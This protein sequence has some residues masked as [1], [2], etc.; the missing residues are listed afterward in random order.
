MLS[1][2]SISSC[3]SI[4]KASELA[5]DSAFFSRPTHSPPPSPPLLKAEDTLYTKTLSLTEGEKRERVVN[6]MVNAFPAW[7]A[8]CARYSRMVCG[9]ALQAAS[10]GCNH[11]EDHGG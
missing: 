7:E 11:L 3:C 4:A 9:P 8:N 6:P 2:A 1:F 10:A 5:C